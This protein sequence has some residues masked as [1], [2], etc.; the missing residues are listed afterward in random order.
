MSVSFPM[1][2]AA[3]PWIMACPKKL[4]ML[5]ESHRDFFFMRNVRN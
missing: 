2:I 4:D 5:M 3:G 1:E